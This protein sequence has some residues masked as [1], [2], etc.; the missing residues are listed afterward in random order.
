MLVMNRADV[1]GGDRREFVSARKP[2]GSGSPMGD[3]LVTSAPFKHP[4]EGW[5]VLHF[6]VPFIASGVSLADD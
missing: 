5:Q 6:T 2:F 1:C 3:V 4:K